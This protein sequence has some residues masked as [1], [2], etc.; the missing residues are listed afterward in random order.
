VREEAAALPPLLSPHSKVVDA[1]DVSQRDSSVSVHVVLPRRH[2]RVQQVADMRRLQGEREVESM[3]KHEWSNITDRDK[4]RRDV[5]A[6]Q[7]SER[8]RENGP[9][10]KCVLQNLIIILH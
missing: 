6:R 4:A 9:G 8:P 2:P 5:R 10:P 7:R 3:V 1:G